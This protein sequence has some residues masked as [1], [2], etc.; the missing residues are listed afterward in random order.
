MLLNPF[1]ET[2]VFGET[3]RVVLGKCDALVDVFVWINTPMID[4]LK[5]LITTITQI[6]IFNTVA[7][8]FDTNPQLK[9]NYCIH[10]IT[11]VVETYSTHEQE[12][13]IEQQLELIV[14][15]SN[16][17]VPSSKLC[18]YLLRYILSAEYPDDDIGCVRDGVGV[19][20]ETEHHAHQ[21]RGRCGG[22]KDS[23][24][25]EFQCEFENGR[26]LAVAT[27]RII[28]AAAGPEF[29][30]ELKMGMVGKRGVNSILSNKVRRLES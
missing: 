23:T 18:Y 30:Q 20:Q 1:P 27:A 3:N 15:V 24:R 4:T 14:S 29:K 9:G 19:G 22:I 7:V 10:T 28:W 13:I 17:V 21:P 2:V 12:F 25:I 8:E 16:R 6:K 5:K 11:R 26:K